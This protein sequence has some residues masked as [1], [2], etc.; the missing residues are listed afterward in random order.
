MEVANEPEREGFI[1]IIDVS[2]G[3]RVV[4]S[5]EFLSPSNKLPGEGRNL[6]LKQQTELKEAGVNSVEI[7]WIRSGRQTFAIP[8]EW[9]PI[10]H[11]RSY[12]ACV[13]RSTAPGRFE[14]YTFPLRQPLPA[15]R[16]PLR[17]SDSDV[18]LELQPL[19]TLCYENGGYDSI[20][21][22]LPLDPPLDPD[23]Q[24]WAGDCVRHGAVPPASE[25]D[26]P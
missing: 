20:D 3:G 16:I 6:Y 7:D 4:T 22:E 26:A 2:T 14:L 19:V 5:I 18:V 21:Y 13:R 9:V 23:D 25:P 24:A 8:P 15:I 17:S 11:R 12:G 10:T 1:E